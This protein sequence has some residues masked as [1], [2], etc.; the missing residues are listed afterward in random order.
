[1]INRIHLLGASGSGT[2]TLA[3]E[4]A[5]TYG[6]RHLDTDDYYWLPTE[7]PF[8]QCREVEERQRLLAEDLL[9]APKWVLS[10]SLCGW[11]DRFIPLF[12]LVIFLWLPEEI[13][14][15]RLREREAGRYGQEV[16]PNGKRYS[17]YLKFLEWASHYDGAGVEMRSRALHEE[18]LM[19]LP[20]PVLRLEGDLSMEEKLATIGRFL[21]HNR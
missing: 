17:A 7:E 15:T 3:R 19:G 4:L 2:S 9:A 12:D 6:L 18:W 5:R 1:M 20:C 11:G 8:T 21:D 14:M 10:G 13:R 16:E